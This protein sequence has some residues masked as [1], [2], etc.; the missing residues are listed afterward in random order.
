SLTEQVGRTLV[1]GSTRP[2]S[3]HGCRVAS[4]K[5]EAA[6]GEIAKVTATLLGEDE[7]TATGLASASYPSSLTLM[8][9]VN[10]VLSLG[11]SAHDVTSFSLE[12]DS[13]LAAD[14]YFLGSQLRE[15]PLEAEFREYTGELETEFQDLTA[16]NRF[17]N[18]TEAALVLTFTGAAI[19]GAFNFATVITAN[20]RFDG[21]TPT[22]G[23]AEIIE[24]PLAYKCLGNTS[25]SALT[26]LYR[27]T[28]TT[29]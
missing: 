3:Y 25:A 14:R 21:E 6:V 26:V 24:Q 20:V 23:G 16:Y 4:W 11:G 19:S 13:G 12:G 18:G 2:F 1:G 10:G 22:V 7:D 27:T 17:V 8:T 5:I 9:F 28:D 15:V 29:P